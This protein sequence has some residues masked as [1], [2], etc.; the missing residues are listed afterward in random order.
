M[1]PAY[2]RRGYGTELLRAGLAVARRLGIDWAL[3]TCGDGN[4]GSA[5]DIGAC[6]GVLQD[7]VAV[8]DGAPKRRYWVPTH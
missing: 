6:G 8:A 1:R 3:A 2:R 7:L 5:A 4:G